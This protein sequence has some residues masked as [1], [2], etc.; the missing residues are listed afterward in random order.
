MPDLDEPSERP[1]RRRPAGLARR[2]V[3]AGQRKGGW[4]AAVRRAQA[5][6]ETAL[7]A[8]SGPA[9]DGPPPTHRWPERDPAAAQ[10]LTAARAV[11]VALAESVS[12][13]AENLLHPDALRKVAWKPPEP[14][15][16]EAIAAQLAGYGARPWQAEL[17]AAPLAAALSELD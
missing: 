1:R 13:P 4:A 16:P 15:T 17:T 6:P 3:R 2:G 8:S 10:R 11:V 5:Q 12:V 9:A 14:R 7:P